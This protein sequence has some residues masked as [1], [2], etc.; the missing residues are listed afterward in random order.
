MQEHAERGKNHSFSKIY[1]DI[2]IS[3]PPCSV[4]GGADA[5]D[6]HLTDGLC[7]MG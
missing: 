5:Y 3:E 4:N 6:S 1:S 2:Y 7:S